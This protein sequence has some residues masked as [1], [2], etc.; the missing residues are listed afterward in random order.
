MPHWEYQEPEGRFF[1]PDQKKQVTVL[2]DAILPGGDDNPGATDA[3]AVEY[4]DRLLA[5]SESTYYDIPRWRAQYG[6]GLPL[7]VA[8][9][10]QKFGG[11]KIEDLKRDEATKL[12][13]DLSTGQ[14]F[15]PPSQSWQTDFFATLRA[16]TIEACFADERWGGNRDNI[17]WQWYGYPTGPAVE[18]SRAAGLTPKNLGPETVYVPFYTPSGNAATAANAPNEIQ[19]STVGPVLLKEA[20]Q[21][22]DSVKPGSPYEVPK[23]V[24][25]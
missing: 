20:I 8:A 7:L 4:V 18:F 22:N 10:T 14:L 13:T 1:S 23:T 5:M 24:P 16:H 11:K 15:G 19:S 17:M 3:N 9:A 2:L 21:L 25:T 6:A 12:L